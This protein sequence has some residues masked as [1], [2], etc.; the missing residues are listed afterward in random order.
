METGAVSRLRWLERAETGQPGSGK[1]AA[2]A[3]LRYEQGHRRAHERMG[4]TTR[5]RGAID[6]IAGK[7]C[8]RRPQ[9]G[10]KTAGQRRDREHPKRK[11]S[12]ERR[13]GKGHHP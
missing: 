5:G 3:A 9:H 2:S 6:E 4:R 10:R 13:R 7:I 11:S 12:V 8:R 1:T